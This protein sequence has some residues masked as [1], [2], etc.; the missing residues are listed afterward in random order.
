MAFLRSGKKRYKL[1]DVVIQYC[2]K[3]DECNCR[4]CPF[5]STTGR[6]IERKDVAYIETY[7]CPKFRPKAGGT[8]GS[9][10]KEMG[11]WK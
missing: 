2:D 4:S 5:E 7:H 10:I 3:K 11:V 9:D 1:A 8:A 6:S